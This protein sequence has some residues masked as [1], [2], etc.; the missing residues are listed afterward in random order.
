MMQGYSVGSAVVLSVVKLVAYLLLSHFHELTLTNAILADT[1]GYGLMYV[2]LRI[3]H[4][5]HCTPRGLG[6]GFRPDADERRRLLR[7][8]FY[9]NFNDAGTLLLTAKSD[10][11][12]IAAL[13]NPV[14]VGTYSFYVRLNEMASQLLPTRQFSNV[15]QP[16][17]FSVPANEASHKIPRYFTF[18]LNIMNLVQLPMTAYA[19]AFH[20]EI[21]TV[22]FGG[23]FVDSSWLLPVIVGFATVSRVGDPVTFVAQ[24]QEKASII[25]LS[26]VFAIYNLVAILLLVPVAGVY[27]A[28]I[29]TGTAQTFKNLFLWWHVRDVA[30]WANFRAVVT[31]TILIWGSCVAVCIGLKNVLA[32]PPLVHLVVGGLI[33]VLAAGLYA[34]SPALSASDRQLLAT[35]LHGREA[36]VLEWLG[37]IPKSV[38]K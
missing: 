4:A 29:A 18:L 27:G 20:A 36:R 24:Y 6:A 34:R 31:M 25:L 13:M 1:L 38:S 33:C 17:F 3:A 37:I 30:R 5:R 23:K 35:I 9:N 21:V 16:L 2:G 7:Y 15:I 19:I 32:A 26:K 10:N 11:L 12:F 28:A 8:S 14:A 22:L